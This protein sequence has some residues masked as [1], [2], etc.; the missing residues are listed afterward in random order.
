VPA[1]I[2]D[3]TMTT[4]A[5]VFREYELEFRLEG[6]REKSRM[7]TTPEHLAAFRDVHAVAQVRE[8]RL[9]W[10]WVETVIPAPR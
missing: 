3:M 1:T 10:P 9:G 4:H 8:G 5:L 6:F 2:L 7:L